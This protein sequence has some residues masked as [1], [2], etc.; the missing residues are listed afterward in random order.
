MK[1]ILLLETSKLFFPK[2]PP[3]GLITLY[4]H[5]KSNKIKSEYLDVYNVLDNKVITK[6]NSNELIK[7]LINKLDDKI[8]KFDVIGISIP[9]ESCFEFVKTLGKK[10]KN[11]FPEKKIIIGGK[12]ISFLFMNGFI[13]ENLFENRFDYAVIL[14]GERAITKLLKSSLGEK[15]LGKIPN[16]IFYKDKQINVNSINNDFDINKQTIIKQNNENLIFE[17][18]IGRGCY[19]NKCTFCAY[20]YGNKINYREKSLSIIKKDLKKNK[21]ELMNKNVFFITDAI[22]PN[23]IRIISET[24]IKEKIKIKWFG[25]LRFDKDFSYELLSLMKKSGC[26]ELVFGLESGDKRINNKIIKK[27][28]KLKEAERIIKECNQL[29]IET[30]VAVVTGFPTETIFNAFN[31]FKFI[32]KNRR[33][34]PICEIYT[35]KLLK[36]SELYKNPKKYGITKIYEKNNEFKFLAKKGN[37][38]Q[39]YLINLFVA[40]FYTFFNLFSPMIISIDTNKKMLGFIK[41]KIIDN[42]SKINSSK[43]RVHKHKCLYKYYT[44]VQMKTE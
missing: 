1:S 44:N 4:E 34:I 27:G 21:K 18:E 37:I 17:Y 26:S 6:K 7:L 2:A 19:Y 16:L 13:D 30:I 14:D 20:K 5:L 8:L 38:Y 29:G 32:Y 39:K 31:T 40:F 24:L 9:F 15:D 41:E 3:F 11:L 23:Q 33:H 35:F 43:N 12:Y 28:I 22:N 10:I 42:L 36:F 25:F